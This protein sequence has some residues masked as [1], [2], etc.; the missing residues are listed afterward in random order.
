MMRS[1]SGYSLD[2]SDLILCRFVQR[3]PKTSDSMSRMWPFQTG[4]LRPD[5]QANATYVAR[6]DAYTKSSYRVEI[7]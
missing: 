7:S 2:K 4:A 1:L 3:L 6:S 5:L